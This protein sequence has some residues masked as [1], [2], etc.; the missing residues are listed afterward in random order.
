MEK[1]KKLV[2]ETNDAALCIGPASELPKDPLKPTE[3]QSSG[4]LNQ[5]QENLQEL[6]IIV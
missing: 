3:N 5:I 4:E 2:E 6:K 1:V